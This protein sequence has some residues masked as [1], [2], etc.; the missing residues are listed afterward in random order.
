[1]CLIERI[2]FSHISGGRDHAKISEFR[3]VAEKLLDDKK[4]A[5]F[6]IQLALYARRELNIRTAA[7]FVIGCCLYKIF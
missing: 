2:D 7:N 3:K 4:N 1:M 5:E 6:V